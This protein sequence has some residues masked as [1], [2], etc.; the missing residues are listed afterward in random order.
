M[1]SRYVLGALLLSLLFIASVW[2][3]HVFI[4]GAVS[5]TARSS[6]YRN[7][8]VESHRHI[9]EH[10]WKA[11]Y[12]MQT[13]LVTPE[14]GEYERVVENLQQ[15]AANVAAVP[16]NQW[17]RVT[18]I[19]EITEQLASDLQAL[20]AGV[21]QLM[22][23]RRNPQELFP[24][25]A[26][27]ND[28]ML[29]QN[30]EFI[31]QIQLV[32]DDLSPRLGEPEI[33]SAYQRFSQIKDEWLDM[34]STFRIYVASR[35]MT[36]REPA[37]ETNEF[38]TVI[39]LHH[40]NLVSQIDTLSNR[41]E[42]TDFGLQSEVSIG[43]LSGILLTWFQAYQEIKTIYSGRY[44]RMDEILMN[45]SIRPMQEVIWNRLHQIELALGDSSQQDVNQLATVASDVSSV[46]WMR[47]MLS[48]VFIGSAFLAF[49]HWVLRPVAKIAHALKMEAD[50]EEVHDLP[51]ANTLET[52]E[53]IEAFNE[54]RAQVRIRQFELEHQA[55]HDNLT[56]L[57]NRL[58]LR[59]RLI[60]AID[61]ACRNQSELALLM[62]DLDRFKEINDTLGHHM[63]D[64]VLEEI[65]PRFKAE[66]AENDMLARLGGDEFAILLPEADVGRANDV[67]AR[68]SYSLDIDF[69][70]DGQLLRVGSSIGIALYPHHG[71]NE[72]SLLQRADVAMYLAKHKNIGFAVYDENQDEHSVWQLS[73]EGE[74]HRAIR[75]D[76]LELHYQPK[77]HVATNGIV[78]VEALLRWNHPLHGLVPADEIHLLAEKTGLIKPLT[79]W[80]I[81]QVVKQ[82]AEWNKKELH[83]HISANLSVWN[84]QDPKLYE[85][86]KDSLRESNVPA[87]QLS[88]EITESA[89][90][91]DPD[92]A[93]DTLEQLSRL[94]IRLSIDDFGIG[95]S[96]LQY[97]KKLPVNEL[98][99]DK[100]FVMDLIV[101]ENDAVIVRST[102][103][104]AHNLG[105]RVIA[106]GVESQEIYDVLQILGC[107]EAQ[108][109]HMAHPMRARE[110]ERW[111]LQSPWGLGKKARLQAVN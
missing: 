27:I 16:R 103:D 69:N 111:M 20:K 47:M 68:L 90:M 23:M 106:E 6:A 89:V 80:V 17:T 96:S 72:Q 79:K 104:L 63:G 38:E 25:Y 10:L 91:S 70:M 88:L 22:R 14:Q 50:G 13:Y 59:R 77:V 33:L 61:A 62:V 108:G 28:V 15:A 1:R 49:E 2:L 78:G 107:D 71:V 93:M 19:D 34:V 45:E 94:G 76:L 37:E 36:I 55:L 54:M 48:L 87:N 12:A 109:F 56:G 30:L 5:H 58:L 42:H 102:I 83:L 11:E 110:L 41:I 100:S 29:P 8:F 43:Q 32:L 81:S 52:R 98:K 24:A 73:F 67:A 31:S 84:L 51:K 105:L 4:S 53:L 75:E 40:A 44:W 92:S 74:L 86:V 26:T 57:P 60:A 18:G 65:G 82:L 7:E 85:C 97:L 99:I 21:D 46:L 3:T 95:F 9:R 35:A 101:D 66:L 64:R 39:E